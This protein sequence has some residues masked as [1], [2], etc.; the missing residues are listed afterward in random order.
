M[1]SEQRGAGE[2]AGGDEIKP[3][4]AL[5]VVQSSTRACLSASMIL[6]KSLAVVFALKYHLPGL[7]LRR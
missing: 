1:Y 7:R 6:G 3:G 4:V 2:G 5:V